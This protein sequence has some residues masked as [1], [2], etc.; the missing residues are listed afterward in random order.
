MR[1][2]ADDDQPFRPHSSMSIERGI[3]EIGIEIVRPR[4]CYLL[5]CSPIN[6]DRLPAPH[7]GH[8]L[9]N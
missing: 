3:N 5:W 1:A 4:I 7:N 2:Y 8:T 9:T 6:K